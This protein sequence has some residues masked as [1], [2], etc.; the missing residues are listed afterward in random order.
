MDLSPLIE[1]LQKPEY[2][3]KTDAEC[4]DMVNAKTVT[5]RQPVSAARI[6]RRAIELG[7]WSDIVIASEDASDVG[8]R[9]AALDVVAWL[10]DP[11]SSLD[12]ID[13]D[14][15]EVQAI[16]AACVTH[17]LISIDVL[18]L[19]QNMPNNVRRWVDVNGLGDVGVSRTK[20][21]RE[22]ANA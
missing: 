21:A 15:V 16:V 1:E 11:R 8:R 4:A 18:G 9:R 14:A 3:G 19:L 17:G 7:A 5:V 10:D 20:E 12:D 22:A 6:K 13:L 2:I